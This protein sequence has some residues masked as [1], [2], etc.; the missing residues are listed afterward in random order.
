MTGGDNGFEERSPLF[1]GY[2][3]FELIEQPAIDLFKSLGW[4]II[5]LHG[6]FGTANAPHQ[7]PEGRESRRDAV[8]PLRLKSALRRLNPE[9]PDA[10]LDEAC[11]SLGSERAALEPVRANAELHELLR[12]GVKVKVRSPRGALRDETV[13]MI[14]WDEPANNEFLL[15]SQVWFAGDLYTRRADLVGFVN[16]L[17]LLLV[18]LKAAYRG[19]SDAYDGNLRDYRSAIPQVFVPNGFVILSNGH[20]AR[21][22][23]AHAPFEFFGEWKK[24]D[25]EEEPG[26]V[27]L[28]TLI[29]G[30]CRPARFLDIVENFIAFQEGKTGLVKV[31][32]KN[33]QFLGVNRAMAAVGKIRENQGRLG[34]F[35]HTQ[36]SGK[37]LSMLFF[38]RKVMRQVP[39]DWT[40]LIV[41]DRKELDDQ[42]ADTF[43]AC[44]AL[45]KDRQ[46]I[47]A[48]TRDHLQQ[49]LK[50]NERFIF[51]LIQ[52]FGTEKGEV[53]PKLSDRS[54]VIVITDEA[55]RSQYDVLAANMRAALPN[56]AFLGFTGTPL[57]AGEEERTR[58]VFGD[59]VSIY[60]FA[61]SIADG[62]TVPL[63][64]ES[65]LP[66]LQLKSADLDDEIA[67]VLDDAGLDPETEDKLAKR[68]AR[69]YHLIT[70]DDRL[71]KI[72]ADLVR[73][74]TGRGYRGKAMFIAIDKATA[75]RMFD[76]VQRHWAAHLKA[77]KERVAG[78]ADAVERAALE[79]QLAWL[80]RTDMAVV[81]SQSQNEIET[82]A[83]Q[84][85]DIRPH[86]QRLVKEA[87]DE[88]F[89][90]PD[91]PLRFVFVCAMWITG[92]DVP[93]CSTIYLD[94]PMKNHTLM[95]TIAR[96]NRVAPGK[97][98]G[99]IV[100]YVG[101]F[102]NLKE[103]LAIYAKP[104]PGVETD[105][106]KEKDQLLTDLK[107]ALGKALAFARERGV[108]TGAV[109]AAEGLA[110][111]AGIRKAAEAILG[112][113]TDKL[114]Y[115]RLVASAWKLFKAVLPDPA[116]LPHRGDMVVL[117]VIAEM[118]RSLTRAAPPRGLDAILAEIERLVDEAIS[119]VA[120][121]A[122]IPKGDDLKKL[123]DL[124]TI[125]FDKLADLF[126]GGSKKTAAELL[127]SKAEARAKQLAS[128]NP[129]RVSLL[130]RLQ[131]LV[132]A[133]NAGS[134]DVEQ[135]FEELMAFVGELDDEEKRH[136][137]EALSEDEL[138]IFDILT[139]PEPKLTKA[140]EIEV[141]KI[142][143]LL[144][145][146]LKKEKLV[147]DWRG[148]E[149][150]KAGV[151][152][153]MREELDLLPEV[154]DRK[155]WEEKVERTYQFVFERFA[156]AG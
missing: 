146:K 134:L 148:K 12:D 14:D 105:L 125:D 130:E 65:R 129:T 131:K 156:G 109:I 73:H 153:T 23:A 118:I 10:A 47:Q 34:V 5:N 92:F 122:P 152:E 91:D 101:V 54:N 52:K 30:T 78:I 57:I 32:A 59:Y 72:A 50:G 149:G 36:G 44:G 63:Y 69:Q 132:D 68:F 8:L 70:N 147:L 25:D 114:E 55:H 15:A 120:I 110:R 74:F 45:T 96:A 39:G 53:Y 71:E 121:R 28:E 75:V 145:D 135:L 98:A 85:L 84:G 99:L 13:R 83:K 116:V 21:L 19:L 20:E 40:F 41:T 102:R 11:G 82:L 64:Y 136:I 79:E 86:R 111:V 29:R 87:L 103:A 51:T 128:R 124:S 49:L 112:K 119:G 56:A 140:Q 62:A 81:V 137:R 144:L 126:A 89:K 38:S 33:H 115:L 6:E 113:D 61:Q 18:E 26:V 100:D 138:A 107:D 24:V 67:R 80:E 7:S 94:K 142:A 108:D 43:S 66:E 76:K 95:Q 88:R 35:W 139:K 48:Q 77:E 9:L 37:S 46:M 60:D 155:L 127:R 93:T 58:E 133:Y 106:I 141:K 2:S 27:S 90:A 143:R 22:G 123:F 150:A 1:G 154:Y 42:I 97:Q 117:Q 31:L 104:R 16:G 151:R 4:R 17:P 3:E